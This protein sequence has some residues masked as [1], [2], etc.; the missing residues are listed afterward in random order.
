MKCTD[1]FGKYLSFGITFGLIFQSSRSKDLEEAQFIFSLSQEFINNDNYQL[2]LHSLEAKK[3]LDRNLLNIAAQY[4]DFFEPLYVLIEK[5]MIK[6]DM[7]E[8][9]FCYRFFS[10]VNN[11]TIQEKVLT[12]HKEYYGNIC[13]LHYVWKEY[14][15]DR[16]RRKVIPLIETD[17]SKIEWYDSIRNDSLQK[18]NE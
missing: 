9:L 7:I 4:L 2:L 5:K 17:L 14:R 16:T 12:P 1:L 13:K 15:R 8:D 11:I 6:I 18:N 3:A 10:V